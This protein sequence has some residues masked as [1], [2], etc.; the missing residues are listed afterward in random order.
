M[1]KQNRSLKNGQRPTAKSFVWRNTCWIYRSMRESKHFF[2]LL[3][4]PTTIHNWPIFH[5]FSIFDQKS[6]IFTSFKNKAG[7]QSKAW[8]MKSNEQNNAIEFYKDERIVPFV[9]K[10][11][12]RRRWRNKCERNLLLYVLTVFHKF[13]GIVTQMN[14]CRR[15]GSREKTKIP[16]WAL[17]I[18]YNFIA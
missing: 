2:L 3:D 14:H 1:R 15:N 16:W 4:G 10:K 12:L 17:F 7:E 8:K 6:G 5:C 18:P 9:K 13:N 11:T